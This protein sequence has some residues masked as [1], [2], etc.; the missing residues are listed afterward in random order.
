MTA[1][2]VHPYSDARPAD[3]QWCSD[4]LALFTTQLP[5]VEQYH[6]YCVGS[7]DYATALR[8]YW[9]LSGHMVIVEHDIVP[10]EEQVRELIDC[11]HPLCTIPYW[12]W[13][14]STGL[15]YAL[16]SAFLVTEHGKVCVPD[17]EAYADFS[18]L[19]LVKL[20]AEFR[21]S[22]GKPS[23]VQWN[24]VDIE[25]NRLVSLGHYRWHIHRPMVEHY[26][27]PRLKETMHAR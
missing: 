16:C 22:V 19:G 17:G 26:H 23:I 8:V 4:Q 14:E 3:R 9:E 27:G 7:T 20:S 12:L 11:P 13:P 10:T 18:A 1:F 15:T 21:A 6:A 24:N 2:I 25:I 5:D